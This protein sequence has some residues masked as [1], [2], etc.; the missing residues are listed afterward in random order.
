MVPR[1][2][3]RAVSKALVRKPT[4][5]LTHVKIEELS[6]LNIFLLAKEGFALKDAQAMVSLS[7]LYLSLRVIERIVGKPSRLKQGKN[8]ESMNGRLSALQS[9]IAF[10]YARVLEHATTVF[11][12]LRLAEEWLAK[13]CRYLAGNIPL[14]LVGNPFGFQAVED[15]LERLELGVYQ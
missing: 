11:G 2:A 6:E 4:E 15:Y 12:T 10:Q 14:D 5:Y 1:I 7:E 13:P 8:D 3:P 9:A